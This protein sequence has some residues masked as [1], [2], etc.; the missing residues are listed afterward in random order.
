MEEDETPSSLTEANL[1]RKQAEEDAKKQRFV[2][3]PPM[4]KSTSDDSPK[5]IASF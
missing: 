1:A 3:V 5:V 2:S 4:V